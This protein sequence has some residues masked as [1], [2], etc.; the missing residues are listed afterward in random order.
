MLNDQDGAGPEVA[1]AR[2]VCALVVCALVACALAAGN[3][4][5]A[6]ASAP[7]SIWQCN[8]AALG[9]K[10]S[11]SYGACR[12]APSGVAGA[13]NLALTYALSARYERSRG[14]SEPASDSGARKPARGSGPCLVT[15]SSRS[16][17]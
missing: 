5:P 9:I 13:A 1:P 6:T 15:A 11:P 14:R 2:V 7:A 16:L 10:S 17:A 12:S 4:R 3:T 8:L